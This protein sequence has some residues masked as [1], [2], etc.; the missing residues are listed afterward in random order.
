MKLTD[1]VLTALAIAAIL[2]LFAFA[3]DGL[4]V[5]FTGDDL[6]NTCLLDPSHE[7]GHRLLPG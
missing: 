1:A 2:I 4:G 6:M 3:A 5:Y 7:R